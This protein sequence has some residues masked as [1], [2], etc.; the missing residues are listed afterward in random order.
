MPQ[1]DSLSVVRKLASTAETAG[2]AVLPI[3]AV[4]H[5]WITVARAPVGSPL[6]TS[7]ATVLPSCSQT[8]GSGIAL[9]G[10]SPTLHQGLRIVMQGVAKS[11][12]RSMES[13][14]RSV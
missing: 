5:E 14:P 8:C 12:G 11:D 1:S 10:A 13:R 2:P 7:L 6:A 9:T 4:A 3:V